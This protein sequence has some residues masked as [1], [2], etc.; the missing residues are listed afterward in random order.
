MWFRTFA[1]VSSLW[2]AA[3]T[4]APVSAQPTNARIFTDDLGVTHEF[5]GKPKVVAW[6][7]LA[8]SLMHFGE[9]FTRGIA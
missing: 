3:L 5:T 2:A 7:H 4:C 1:F 6:S 9:F 8:I